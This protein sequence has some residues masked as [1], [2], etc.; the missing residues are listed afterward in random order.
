MAED[1]Q[2]PKRRASRGRRLPEIRVRRLLAP[3]GMV[4]AALLYLVFIW[5]TPW[6]YLGDNQN[7]RAHRFTG[8][9]QVFDRNREEW[10]DVRG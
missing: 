3:G 2:P 9:E 6:E 7:R 1:F 8:R 4:A 10:R 5:P